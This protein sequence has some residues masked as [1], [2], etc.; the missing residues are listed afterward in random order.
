MTDGL[1]TS[2]ARLITTD[3]ALG[4]LLDEIDGVERY[5]IDTEFH[6]ERTYYPR[7]ALV[8][9][10]WA[11]GIALVDPQAVEIAALARL[12]DSPALALVHACDQDLEVLDRACDTLPT[13]MFDTQ[14]A[15]GFIGMSSPSLLS[16]TERL[17][18]AHL[19]KG[20]QL[21]DWTRRPLNAD[22]LRYAASDVAWL[23]A[24]HDELCERLRGL[25]RL[26]WAME[27]CDIALQ[28]GRAPQVPEEAWWKL[29]QARQLRG[30]A[31]GVA[32]EVCAFRERR[33]QQLDVPVRQV[34]PDLA[35][36]SIAQRPPKSRSDL[37]QV[38]TID[39][40]HLGGGAADQL[41][42]A[43]ERGISL[44]EGELHLPPGPNGDTAAK[45]AVALAAAWAQ[46]RARQLQIDPA[47]LATRADVVSYLK[48]P[49]EGRLANSWRH[50]LVGEPIRRLVDGEVAV[51]FER[52]SLV[53][54]ER[55]QRPVGS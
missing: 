25:G 41:L 15:A 30:R 18:G 38:R 47:I 53:L 12:L 51:A 55:S 5:G 34:L 32:Q 21:T 10:S 27:E 6:R 11:E 26:E 45:P 13:R 40:R 54:E 4:A 50:D 33:A 22:Q 29:R 36:A 17:C 20:D 37:E 2:N 23:P 52:G 14:I 39:G 24:L 8:Q 9:L 49:P 42:G 1:D 44:G 19:E 28:R 48:E 43:I 16:L 7:L 3:D 31:R 46:E 35:I